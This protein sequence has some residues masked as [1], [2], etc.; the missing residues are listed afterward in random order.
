MKFENEI[1]QKIKNWNPIDIAFIE[2]IQLASD[3]S[4]LLPQT[5]VYIKALSQPRNKY[6]LWPNSDVSFD[7][8]EFEFRYV[9]NFKVKHGGKGMLQVSGF[10]ITDIA[11]NGME[12]ANFKIEDYENGSVEFFCKEIRVLAIN[13]T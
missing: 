4:S 5:N 12:N 8:I 1:R 2:I 7:S 3:H 11:A 13:N 10:E 9:S 6:S